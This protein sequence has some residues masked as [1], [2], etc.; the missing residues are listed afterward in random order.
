MEIF[1]LSTGALPLTAGLF[2]LQVRMRNDVAYVEEDMVV[3]KFDTA[4]T[5]GLD[6]VDQRYLPLDTQDNFPG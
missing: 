6:R 2:I 5:W 1:P 3:E 4:A